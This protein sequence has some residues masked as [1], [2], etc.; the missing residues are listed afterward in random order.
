MNCN[1]HTEHTVRP[2]PRF[3]R[4]G[5][6]NPYKKC[7]SRNRGIKYAIHKLHM[8]RGECRQTLRL[9]VIVA[10][11]HAFRAHHSTSIM[12][13]GRSVVYLSAG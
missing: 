6:I 12:S 8:F 3:I 2:F 10:K 7:K 4:P 5:Y 1:G 9:M 13:A 11:V